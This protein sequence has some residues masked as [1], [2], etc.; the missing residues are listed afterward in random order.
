MDLALQAARQVVT[1]HLR[2][3]PLVRSRWAGASLKL[4]CVQRTGAYKVRGALAAL[5]AAVRRGD[6]RPVV[7]ASAGNHAAGMAWAARTL[8][9]GA[10]AVV[11]LDAPQSKIDRT[12]A[13]GAEVIRYGRSFEDALHHAKELARTRGWRFLHAFDDLEVMAGQATVGSELWSHAPDV[14]LV[15]VGG[16]GLASGVALAFAGTATR[17]IGVRVCDQDRMT[18]VADG[19]R[20]STLGALTSAVLERHLHQLVWVTDVEVQLAMRGLYLHDGLVVEGAGAVS[21][22]GLA[23]VHGVR[24]VAV[25]S[26]GN[27]DRGVF[28]GVVGR[29]GNLEAA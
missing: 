4:E 24:K 9:L 22:A 8:G 14:V 16:G 1:Q 11:P 23:K 29:W 7:A 26:G 15:P 18:S 25:V 20:V 10:T 6:R 27:V 21:V 13:L 3:T 2:P 28:R 17:V 19:V 12:E 5:S